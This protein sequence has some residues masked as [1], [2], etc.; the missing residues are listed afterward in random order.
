MSKL[1]SAVIINDELTSQKKYL[2]KQKTNKYSNNL[3]YPNPIKLLSR[4]VQKEIKGDYLNAE[5][6]H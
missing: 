2:R 1:L 4:E 5:M 3:P 6:M